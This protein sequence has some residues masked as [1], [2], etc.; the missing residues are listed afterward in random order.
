MPTAPMA[1]TPPTPAGVIQALARACEETAV[2]YGD[3][4][5]GQLLLTNPG[6]GGTARLAIARAGEGD[7]VEILATFTLTVTPA[8]QARQ[9][10]PPGTPERRCPSTTGHAAIPHPGHLWT[11]DGG[12]ARPTQDPSEAG[13]AWCDGELGLTGTA[14]G[15]TR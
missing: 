1:P 9:A 4:A 6:P 14:T 15:S 7:S 8:A 5:H 2:F 12:R 13:A 11:A 3:P 10:A